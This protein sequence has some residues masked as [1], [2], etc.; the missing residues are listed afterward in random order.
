MT[1]SAESKPPDGRSDRV[2][3][4]ARW[5][6]HFRANRE[7]DW[8]IPWDDPS[9][10]DEATR[11]RIAWSIAE[12]QRGESSDARGYLA[13]SERFSGRTGDPHFH[14]TSVL[15]VREEN[16]HSALLLRFM[17]LN[18]IPAIRASWGDAVF[19]WLRSGGDLGWASRVLMV[20]ELIAQEYYPALREA[21]DHPVLRR[22]CNKIIFDEESHITFQ[23]ERIVRV[24]ALLGP[25]AI[26]MRH[27]AQ[28][29]LM[30]GAAV[31][32]FCG[33]RRVFAGQFTAWQFLLRCLARNAQALAVITHLRR[34]RA[35]VHPDGV[36][37]L[38][39]E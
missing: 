1:T 3:P 35:V 29:V 27:L 11:Q 14:A 21:T 24:E 18:G 5:T 39:T 38:S 31:A 7:R 28:N 16:G 20:A 2:R 19:R 33:H 17:Q 4:S 6:A 34:E 13:K 26:A 9:T 8:Q 32:V 37:R 15:F 25:L 12:F 36:V 10:L 30:A 22:I 23:I